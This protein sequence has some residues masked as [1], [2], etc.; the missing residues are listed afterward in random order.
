MIE[1]S[2]NTYPVRK[3]FGQ[4]FLKDDRVIDRIMA[5]AA[6]SADDHVVEIGP[7]RGA[8]TERLLS[9]GATVVA[10]EIDRDLHRGLADRFGDCRR[11]QP[12]LGDILKIDWR[13]LWAADKPCK[14]VANLPYNIASPIFFRLVAERRHFSRLVVMV[15]KEMA[16]RLQHRGQPG[17]S[18]KDYGVLSVV[19]YS[20]FEVDTVCEV[21]PACFSPRP[22]VESTVLRLVPKVLLPDA[23]EA[24]FRFVQR[25]FS[26]RRKLL[27]SSLKR[28]SPEMFAE[29][30]PDDRRRMTGIRPE[31]L[32]PEEYIRLYRMYGARSSG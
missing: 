30:S 29:L 22:Q 14:L 5:A 31:N 6:V 18:L 27:L 8:L 2:K 19:A 11:L 10:V 28:Q 32:G 12:I 20:S 26:N 13:R 1:M 15:Q 23:S 7:G 16:L 24:F 25:M 4:H 17:G 21:S 9:R 3:R